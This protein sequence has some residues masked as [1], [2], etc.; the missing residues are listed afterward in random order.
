MAYQ[1]ILFANLK[2]SATSIQLVL[3]CFDVMVPSSQPGHQFS[4][5]AE[6]YAIFVVVLSVHY[7]HN[8]PLFMTYLKTIT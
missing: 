8:T 4:L 1:F 7:P 2:T 3:R 5:W 6:C